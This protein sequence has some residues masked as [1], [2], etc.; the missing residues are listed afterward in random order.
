MTLEHDYLY[1]DFKSCCSH[2]KYNVFKILTLTDLS[3]RGMYKDPS[4]LNVLLAVEMIL[5]V[6][7]ISASIGKRKSV[8]MECAYRLNVRR[9]SLL[10]TMR[11]VALFC[12]TLSFK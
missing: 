9:N 4:Y 5:I 1:Y 7:R 8:I 2:L 11:L 12:Q 10:I 3:G 6:V